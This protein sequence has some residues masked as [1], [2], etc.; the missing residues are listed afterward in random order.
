MASLREFLKEK[1]YYRIK[2]SETPTGHFKFNL[3]L[4]DVA[5]SFILDTGAS[6]TCVDFKAL[7]QFKLFAEDSDIKAAGAGAVDMLTQLSSKNTIS[8]KKWKVKNVDVVLFDLSHVNMAL[9]NHDI[10]AVD[11][12]IGADILNRAKAVIDYEYHC[13]YIKKQG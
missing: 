12:I 2:L 5:G 4:N 3:K 13:L 6:N 7:D 1:G 11:G 10:L 8:I 9:T